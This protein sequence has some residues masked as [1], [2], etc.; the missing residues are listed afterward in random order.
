[1]ATQTATSSGE[2]IRHLRTKAS[3]TLQQV[4]EGADT[5][6]AY[7]SKVERDQFNPTD[8]YVAKV[9]VFIASSMMRKAGD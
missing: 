5:S 9:V 2:A 4:A 1:M 7:L 3:L 8:D 6:V